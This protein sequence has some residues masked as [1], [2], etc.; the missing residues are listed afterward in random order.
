ML[1]KVV[2]ASHA[3]PHVT[4]FERLSNPNSPY[5]KLVQLLG[6]FTYTSC[7]KASTNQLHGKAILSYSRLNLVLE[8]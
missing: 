2:H 1:L 7:C 5:E 4:Y 6:A 8:G 3:E